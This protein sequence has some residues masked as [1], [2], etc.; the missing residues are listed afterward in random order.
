MSMELDLPAE[1]VEALGPEP[2]REALEGILLLLVG[3]G[4]IT[5]ERAGALLGLENREKAVR[6][7]EGR[8]SSRADLQAEDPART[9]EIVHLEDLTQEELDRLERFLDIP[10]ASK[11]SGLTDVSVNHDKYLAEDAS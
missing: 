2:E 7:Y 5:L 3:E 9:E 11:G 1:V 10:P 6:W 4:R 8:A